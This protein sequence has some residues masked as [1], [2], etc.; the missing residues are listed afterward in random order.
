MDRLQAMSAFVTVV[1]C[2]G[3]ASAARQ[4]GLSPPVV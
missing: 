4:L 2:G 3:F 1:D